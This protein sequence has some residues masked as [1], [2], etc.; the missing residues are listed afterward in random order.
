MCKMNIQGVRNSVIG[1][2]AINRIMGHKQLVINQIY[3]YM[4]KNG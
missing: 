4:E 2:V 3:D 1:S